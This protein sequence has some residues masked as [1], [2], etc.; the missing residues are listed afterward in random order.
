MAVPKRK[1]GR[2]V[3]NSRRSCHKL[4]APARSLCPQ[5]HQVKLPHRVCGECGYYDGKEIVETD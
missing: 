5:C 2:S 4:E 1:T 3:T